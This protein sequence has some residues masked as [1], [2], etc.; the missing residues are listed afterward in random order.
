MKLALCA[1]VCA[2]VLVR[3]CVMCGAV[4]GRAADQWPD[5]LVAELPADDRRTNCL[6]ERPTG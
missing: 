1:C 6:T 4:L 3:V 5:P 2:R